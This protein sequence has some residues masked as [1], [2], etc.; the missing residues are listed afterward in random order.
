MASGAKR[1]YEYQ[2]PDCG[3]SSERTR[4]VKNRS[5]RV[6][7]RCG[8]AMVL[9]ISIPH[10]VKR[11]PVKP[12]PPAAPARGSIG[13]AIRLT[14]EAIGTQLTNIGITGANIGVDV[15]P[16]A[17]VDLD[18]VKFRRTRT[19]VRSRDADVTGRD[20]TYD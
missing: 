20:I 6:K 2:C 4:L 1:T 16:G 18:G 15:E 5:K 3:G 11:T 13:T 12:R 17:S 10:I 9:Q 8:A 14:G 7:C 19:G